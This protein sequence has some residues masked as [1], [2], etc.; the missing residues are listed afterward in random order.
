MLVLVCCV[1]KPKT[2]ESEIHDNV[3][4]YHETVY[5]PAFPYPKQGIIK[6]LDA[7]NNIVTSDGTEIETVQMP[8][9]YWKL[10]I[11]YVAKT[12]NAVDAITAKPP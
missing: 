6:P 2:E 9:W 11:D 5:F 12:E 8:Y 3:T 1:T 4:S 7:E 10:V